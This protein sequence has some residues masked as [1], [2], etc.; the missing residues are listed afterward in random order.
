MTRALACTV[1]VGAVLAMGVAGAAQSSTTINTIY[2]VPTSHYDFG[3]VDPPDAVRERAARHIDAVLRMADEDPRF[4]WT[5]ESVW[6]V[7]EWLKRAKAPSSILPKDEARI[8]RLVGY[9]KSGKIA[10]STSWGSMHTDFLGVEEMNRLCADY[11]TLARSY[12]IESNFAVMDDVPGHPASVPSVLAASGVKYLLTGV[13]QAFMGGTSLAPGK[14][15]F[16][17]EGPDGG[18]VLTWISQGVRGGYVEGFTDFYLDPFTVDPY[19]GKTSYEIF[20]PNAP[21][22]KPPL[23]IMEEGVS[24]LLKRYA[25]AGYQ[26]DAVLVMYAHD[27]IEP[28][29]VKNVE[30]AIDLWNG[31]HATPTLK[32]ATPP[33]FFHDMEQRDGAR[34]ATTRGEWSGLWSE[35][36]TLSPNMSALA[37][38]G[39]DHAP[40]AETLWS[41][42][43]MRRGIPHPVGSI[44]SIFDWLF[45][46]DEH[47]GAGN[48]GW[49]GL[50]TRAALEEQNRQ[51]ATMLTRARNDIDALFESGLDILAEPAQVADAADGGTWPLLVY[52]ALS[53]PRT[54]AVTIAP[55]RPGFVI[56]RVRRVP[57][58]EVVPFDIMPDGTAVFLATDVPS[59][60]YVT[61]L[62]DVGTGAMLSRT[63]LSR[64]VEGTTVSS[65]YYRA[66]MVDGN[67]TSLVALGSQT[68]REL[69]NARGLQRFDALQRTRGEAPASVPMPAFPQVVVERGQILDRIVI[70]R[71][72]SPYERS[73]IT[74]YHDLDRVD[75]RNEIDA[76]ALPFAGSSTAWHDAY[77]FAFPFAL[78]PKTL[79]VYSEGQRGFRHLPDD[80]LPGARQDA[81]T[82][83]HVIAMADAQASI[84]LAHRQAFHFVFPGGK[85]PLAEATLLSKAF[86]H[87]NQADTHD[88]GIVQMTTGD[89]EPGLGTRDTFEYALRA[90]SAPFDPV[91]ATRLGW[92]F[93]VPLRAKF[94]AQ[95]PTSSSWSFASVDQPNV[96][97]LTIKPRATLM[98]ERP[99]TSVPL[100][101]QATE[102]F[103]VRVQEVA[104]RPR[105]DAKLTIAS[106]Q[107]IKSAASL[108]LTEDRVLAPLAAGSG[109]APLDVT[110]GPYEV[111]SILIEL[112]PPARAQ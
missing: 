61:F 112:I 90:G 3:F 32:I 34:L 5:I 31:A 49:P 79:A 30:R 52:N 13:N 39:H 69:V 109:R 40:A 4:R 42:I 18:R 87:G 14:L 16:Y 17:W 77:Y 100:T 50:N 110:L 45:T 53:W 54:D 57:G 105:T 47:S 70:T 103:V 20:N 59:L 27:F 11:A 95:A 22:G 94:V 104:G 81:T 76:T 89:I 37:R 43:A 74:L 44:R 88:L 68:Q 56:M 71:E 29:D 33:E 19:I 10:L 35:A 9:L 106:P 12:G 93:N 64:V 83:Q 55:P 111:K 25:D 28:T 63:T 51:Y 73:I 107:V 24:T 99:V 102:A 6:Q 67:L 97:I 84:M 7:N 86:R 101:P 62:A 108:S 91:A 98:A 48:T 66:R 36:K 38:Y 2:I 26:H 1:V 8:A 80:L 65:R 85:F 15:P 82:S 58:G 41:A 72:R 78:D 96:Q 46:F 21:K 23:E 92:E 75:I 60:G